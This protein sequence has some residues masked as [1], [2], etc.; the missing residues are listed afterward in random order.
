MTSN[1]SPPA[2]SAAPTVSPDNI[3]AAAVPSLPVVRLQDLT[4]EAALDDA[5][6]AAENTVQSYGSDWQ[7]WLGFCATHDLTPMPADPE[8][9]RLYLVQLTSFGGRQGRPLRPRTA[10]R[11]LAAIAAAHR[12]KDLPF[13]T[14]HP[15]LRRTL[16]GIKRRHGTRQAGSD[17]LRTDTIVAICQ[18]LGLDAHGVRN[19]AI[20][21]LGFA[22][23]FRRSELAALEVPDLAFRNDGLV[24]TLQ[25]SKT[26]QHGKGRR[27]GILHGTHPSTCPIEAVRAWMRL[28]EIE[29]ETGPLFRP[30]NRWGVIEDFQ[31]RLSDKGIDRAVKAACAAAGLNGHYSAHSLRAGHVTEAK[32]RGA[33]RGRVKKQTGHASDRMI[34]H[35][36]QAEIFENNSSGYLGL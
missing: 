35:Y 18:S 6:S 30:I 25:R 9:V 11:H 17:A 15:V 7:S 33:D 19:K 32:G 8:H 29:H 13:D 2:A 14:L 27:V 12:A 24:V 16:D 21:L 4:A 22:G 36:D 1:G 34:D 28:A 31:G 5:R 26:D 20:V 10:E 3:G 23:G